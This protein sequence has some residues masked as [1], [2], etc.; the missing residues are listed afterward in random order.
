MD[1]PAW[2]PPE[3]DLD[4][5]SPARIY[6]YMLGGL[7][8]FAVDRQM[9]E[10]IIAVAPEVR[11]AAHAN[12]GF[13]RRAVEYLAGAGVRQFLDLGSGIP[14]VGNVHEAARSVAPDARVVYVD[15]DPVAVA[16][17]RAIVAEDDQVTVVHADVRDVEGVLARPEL[18]AALDLKEPVAVLMVAVLHFIPDSDAPAAMIAKLTDAVAPG[19]YLALS[20]VTTPPQTLTPEQQ[21]A[22]E[23]YTKA[24]PVAM[25]T[26]DE[27]AGFFAGLE[28]VDPG[29]VDPARWRADEDEVGGMV[30]SFAGVAR[31][32]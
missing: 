10:Q 24:N 25:R 4:R 7:H 17:S 15:V 6:D 29:L 22:A 28:L 27:I 32:P 1:R 31:K 11:L 2:A 16:H 30:S 3:V 12:R 5:P 20:Q 21:A 18:H 8:N 26:R 23:R 13:L 9:A 19:S 14:T